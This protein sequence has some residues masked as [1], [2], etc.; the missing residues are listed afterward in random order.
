M[1]IVPAFNEEEVFFAE[2][3]VFDVCQIGFGVV[4]GKD[5]GA[6]NGKAVNVA[7]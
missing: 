7:A 1:M 4:D 2:T 6:L 5:T 3:V